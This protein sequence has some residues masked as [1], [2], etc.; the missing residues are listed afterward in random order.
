MQRATVAQ[1]VEQLTRNEQVVRSNRISSSSKG[2]E[3]VFT[4]SG[5]FFLFGRR[6]RAAQLA[7]HQAA[8]Q[9]GQQRA[10]G[11][12]PP[13]D[14]RRSVQDRR[15]RGCPAREP[16]QQPEQPQRQGQME[17]AG[18]Q[19]RAEGNFRRQMVRTCSRTDA[20]CRL[21]AAQQS[22]LAQRPARE[23]RSQPEHTSSIMAAGRPSPGA[24]A[25][26]PPASSR[27]YRMNPH[28]LQ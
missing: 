1:P 14:G 12:D 11:R 19:Q 6:Q 9:K 15:G 28:S 25:L 27:K 22:Q 17:Q 24:A 21:M 2:S 18:G 4:A 10:V 16:E 3:A 13:Q 20:P 8:S 26:K 23:A 7:Y 5:L